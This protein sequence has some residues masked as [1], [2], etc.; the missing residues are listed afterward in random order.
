MRW[1]LALAVAFLGCPPPPAPPP[2]SASCA[3]SP[4]ELDFGEVD[5]GRRSAT[6]SVIFRN[7]SSTFRVLEVTEPMAPF[8][9]GSTQLFVPAYGTTVL[10]VAFL[11]RDGRLHFGELLITDSLHSGECEV[12]VGLRGLGRGELA[13]GPARF[14]LKVE[15]GDVGTAELMITNS[16]RQAVELSAQ[17]QLQQSF[18]G[19]D[20]VTVER[21]PTVVPP[22]GSLALP[23][24]GAPLA[25]DVVM[26]NVVVTTQDGETLR[27]QFRMIA[28]RPVAEVS[29]TEVSVWRAPYD[30]GSQPASFS[31]RRLAIRN[32]GNSGNIDA[33]K[34]RLGLPSVSVEAIQACYGMA[35]ATLAIRA[36]STS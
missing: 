19:G 29:P 12:R 28:G 31:R 32:V 9:L 15:P 11:P 22:L 8:S 23:V 20:T 34:L 2:E 1:T 26:G 14:D 4:L 30:P 18:A 10:E 17:V 25:A 35:E 13:M 24:R 16:R 7:D 5:T 6:R 3:A 21:G 27:S 33:L 36:R